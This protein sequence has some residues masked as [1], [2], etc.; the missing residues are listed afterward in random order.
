[1]WFQIITTVASILA[2]IVSIVSLMISYK[3][4]KASEKSAESAKISAG[5]SMRANNI[6][7]ADIIRPIST[8]LINF[9]KFLNNEE[10]W[11][12][13]EEIKLV[14]ESIHEL[15]SLV[16]GN[17]ELLELLNI[18]DTWLNND[19]SQVI[20]QYENNNN[21]TKFGKPRNFFDDNIEI[22]GQVKLDFQN[23]MQKLMNLDY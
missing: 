19:F 6:A 16:S 13:M 8:N 2:I 21:K 7:R 23:I 3:S 18:I 11:T 17:K 5:E 9:L 22:I 20:T 10:K 15:R 4:S 1:M 12:T 14:R